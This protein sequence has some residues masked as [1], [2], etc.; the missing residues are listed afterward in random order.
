M[1]SIQDMGGMQG[2][3]PVMPEHNEPIFHAEWEKRALALTLAMGAAGL[4]NID[5]SRE[6]RESLD[7]RIYLNS[8]YYEI[9]IRAM[10]N[11]MRDYGVVTQ[12][13]LEQG[14]SLQAPSPIVQRRDSEQIKAALAKGAPTERYTDQPAR[15][16]VG[17]R[18]LALNIHPKGHTRLPRYVRGHVG[19]VVMVHGAHVYPD[20]HVTKRVAPFDDRPE[21]LYT[22]CFDGKTLWGPHA[23]AN[24]EV[25]VDAW[26]PYLERAST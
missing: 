13:E 12:E 25:T 16:K 7:P 1:N 8:S 22:V 6:A 10:E 23:E 4:W 3:G 26:E 11:L 21:W 19:T 5:I 15:F 2:F 18:V 9:W 24:S 14:R 20:R 17:D